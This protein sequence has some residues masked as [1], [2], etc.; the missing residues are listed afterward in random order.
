MRGSNERSPADG[1]LLSLHS[2]P[3]WHTCPPAFTACSQKIPRQPAAPPAPA[4]ATHAT[5]STAV[6]HTQQPWHRAINRAANWSSHTNSQLFHIRRNT[7]RNN[8]LDTFRSLTGCKVRQLDSSEKLTDTLSPLDAHPTK[9]RFCTINT[10]TL[11][12]L[13]TKVSSTS[14]Y[15]CSYKLWL[16]NTAVAST[17]H[18]LLTAHPSEEKCLS[19]K[20]RREARCQTSCP[21]RWQAA[22]GVV[23]CT[24]N[25]RKEVMYH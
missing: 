17:T 23:H 6:G 1:L 20:H 5:S 8:P 12:Y 10:H 24:G 18:S 16:W 15:R 7:H 19:S 3:C 9:T 2:C 13:N 11:C 22:P 4:A 25:G 21:W 14:N